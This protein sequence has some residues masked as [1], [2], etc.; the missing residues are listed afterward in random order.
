MK[1]NLG[2]MAWLLTGFAVFVFFM[3]HH[4]R[5][6]ITQ[7]NNATLDNAYRV[8]AFRHGA[9][10]IAYKNHRFTAK[11]RASLTWLNG[12]DQPG[13]PMTESDCTYMSDKVG[14]SIGD[15]LMRQENSSLVFA[16]WTGVDTLQTADYLTITDDELV[17]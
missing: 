12:T 9:Y 6:D 13:L 7:S 1:V 14:R 11:C 4:R 3:S 16:P 2:T 8:L 5:P 15:D 10:I 17:K